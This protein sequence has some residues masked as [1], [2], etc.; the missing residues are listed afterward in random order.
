MKQA[1]IY[2]RISTN[3]EKQNIEQQVEYCKKWAE[4][5]GYEVIKV[6]RDE[7]TGK[8]DNRRGYQRMLKYLLE[9][10]VVLI[11]QDT[12]RLTRN[13]YDGVEFEKF[14]IE[15]DI[16]VKSLSENIDL[17]SPNGRF[18]WRIKLAMNNFYVEN[19]VDKIRVGVARAKKE[20]KYLGRKKGSINSKIFKRNRKKV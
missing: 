16:I 17:K 9:N 14:V 18:M 11:V 2:T 4:R 13:F 7:K 8:T 20:G 1:A 15:N 19:L 3:K 5:E 12:D 6:F 10:D